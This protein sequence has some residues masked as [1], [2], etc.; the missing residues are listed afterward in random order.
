LNVHVY[1]VVIVPFCVRLVVKPADG[2][3]VVVPVV[4]VL[5][6]DVD[7]VVV[8]PEGP[9]T[10]AVGLDV[11]TDEPFLFVAVTV[12]R[13]VAPASPDASVYDAVPLPTAEHELP[14]ES[15]RCHWKVYV[16]VGPA[17]V[18]TDAV[19]VCPTAAD[20]EI[21]GRLVLPGD[22]CPG[23]VEEADSA[24]PATRPANA[25]SRSKIG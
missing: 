18:P 19:S 5:V 8:C 23:A 11:A 21:D 6:V 20:P 14:D 4:V 7:V 12:T 17:Q 10:T 2:V 13:I 3:V 9:V 24:P 15:Q 1:G 16:G 22:D 25:S